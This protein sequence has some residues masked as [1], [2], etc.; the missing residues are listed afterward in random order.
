MKESK[1][2]MK[3]IS[4][5]GGERI[6]GWLRAGALVSLLV[7]LM[8]AQAAVIDEIK[9]TVDNI[10]TKVTNIKSQ[11]NLI[12]PMK[13]TVGDIQNSL[14]DLPSTIQATI[15]VNI[16][17]EMKAE[18]L[19]VID[20][21]RTTLDQKAS[22]LESFGDGSPG[23]GCYDFRN[24]I[25]AFSRDFIDTMFLLESFGGSSIPEPP[26][27]RIEAAL[28]LIDVL[29]CKLLLPAWLGLSSGP[30][31][32]F[33]QLLTTIPEDLRTVMP[34]FDTNLIPTPF[35][36]NVILNGLIVSGTCTY[37]DVTNR[38]TRWK[39]AG[40]GTG[41]K[42]AGIS[43]GV[44]ASYLDKDVYTGGFKIEKIEIGDKEV[45]IHGY[46]SVKLERPKDTR[47]KIAKGVSAL[48][49]IIQTV[50]DYVSNKVDTC[51]KARNQEVI[52]TEICSLSRFRSEACQELPGSP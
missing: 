5:G 12:G 24:S 32:G 35:V 39:F 48:S 4:V 50:A 47:H 43:L 9:T 38:N 16:D 30:V 19:D 10:N 2:L 52:L 14:Q 46:G 3:V 27:D 22:D 18:I 8:T 34:L 25:K 51:I 7:P 45:G 17:P 26:A 13:S 6:V 23:T 44:F 42:V 21:F 40:A 20:S 36:P 1:R 31:A 49:K 15:G 37:M 28:A 41:L 29:D 33:A 11:T